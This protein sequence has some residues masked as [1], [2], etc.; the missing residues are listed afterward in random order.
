LL[1]A[2]PLEWLLTFAGLAGALVAPLGASALQS[3][4]EQRVR[5]RTMTLVTRAFPSSLGSTSGDDGDGAG[6]VGAVRR[7]KGK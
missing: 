4:V 6:D 1:D 5:K 3:I 2:L 7:A